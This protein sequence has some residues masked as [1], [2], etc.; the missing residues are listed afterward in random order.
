MDPDSLSRNMKLDQTLLGFIRSDTAIKMVDNDGNTPLGNLLTLILD[1]YENDELHRHH[2]RCF[3]TI[4]SALI[5]CGAEAGIVNKAG[6]SVLDLL[7]RVR[8]LDDP[9]QGI[10]LSLPED[11]THPSSPKSWC[12]VTLPV[13]KFSKAEVWR[14][15]LACVCGSA[16]GILVANFWSLESLGFSCSSG[17]GGYGGE[18][19]YPVRSISGN[20]LEEISSLR[21]N[22]TTLLQ[23]DLDVH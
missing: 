18:R 17:K 1:I 10:R 21:G 7:E 5:E 20:Q 19:A 4:L 22:S 23:A 6:E 12:S 2:A 14:H 16:N 8:G 15:V 11:W 9:L 13:C 3:E